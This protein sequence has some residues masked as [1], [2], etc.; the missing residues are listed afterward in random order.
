MRALAIES[1]PG[2]Q[3][4]PT[5]ISAANPWLN[6][7]R[8][9]LRSSE[10]GG[11]ARLLRNASPGL[12]ET[13]G[14]TKTL[15]DEQTNL[16]RCTSNV[17][18]PAGDIVINDEFSTGQPNY[19][20]FF[21]SAVQLAGESQ[22]FDGNGPYVRFQSGGGP[23][24]LRGHEPGRHAGHRRTLPGGHLEG[25][26]QRDRGPAGDPAGAPGRRPAVPHGRPLQAPG[27]AADQRALGGRRDRPT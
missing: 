9:L 24:L 21:Y 22:G 26:R 11:L 17:L 19:R 2:I 15:F 1:R 8:A 12:A 13:A 6:Q 27:G 23:Q 16:A 25:I 7:T 3:E 10:L 14:A 18:V 20:E 5:T 4:L